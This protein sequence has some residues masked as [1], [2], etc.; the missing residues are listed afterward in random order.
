MTVAMGPRAAM[1]AGKQE[2]VQL[3]RVVS[4]SRRRVQAGGKVFCCLSN[5]L[6]VLAVLAALTLSAGLA[7]AESVHVSAAA[8]AGLPQV[9]ARQ[10]ALDRALVEAVSKEARRLLS[11]NFAEHRM[12]ALRVHLAPHALDYVLAYQEVPAVKPSLEE[13]SVDQNQNTSVK[14]LAQGLPLELE[15]NV[16][17]NRAY[18]RQT[19]VRLGFF[20]GRLHP[21]VYVLRLGPGVTEKDAKGLEASN[22]L[23]GLTRGSLGS[24]ATAPEVTL[25]RLPQGYY[26]AVLRQGGKVLAAD[27]ADLPG[28]W[29]EVWGKYFAD[30]QRQAGPGM[31]RLTFAGFTSVDGVMDFLLAAMAWDEAVQEAKLEIIELAGA[32]IHAQFT[33]RV[34]SQQA[35]DARLREVLSARKLSLVSQADLSGSASQPVVVSGKAG[36]SAP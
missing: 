19:L 26:K 31:Q 15:L 18:L 8:D 14:P 25:E 10:Q 9:Q 5:A 17:V 2:L 29:F 36:L 28:L 6:L 32:D 13:S 1:A 30:A 4:V 24:S 33:C 23:L 11:G 7:R 34:V 16:D 21:G 22:P 35:L 20:A 27:A 12:T 3:Q